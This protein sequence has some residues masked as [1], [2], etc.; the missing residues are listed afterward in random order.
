MVNIDDHKDQNLIELLNKDLGQH[1][2]QIIQQ[3]F[4]Q[5]SW[6]GPIDT[7]INEQLEVSTQVTLKGYLDEAGEIEYIVSTFERALLQ[8]H[9]LQE[10]NLI[11]Q[12]SSVLASLREL[13][14]Y[15]LNMSPVNKQFSS[16]LLLDTTAESML[17][18]ISD[19]AQIENR[20]KE[21]ESRLFR[22]LP[23]KY[24]MAK[25]QLGK[26]IIILPNT[27]ADQAHYFALG[28]LNTLQESGLGDGIC[29]GIASYQEDQSLEQFLSNAEIALKRAKQI[30]EHNICQ[31]FTRQDPLQIPMPKKDP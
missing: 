31:A 17:S 14:N 29:I 15:F 10:G 22:E 7:T 1:W 28:S 21:V 11:P 23:H 25:W 26:L 27:D 5:G 3:I 16:L 30:G 9:Y 13:E 12:R 24:Q 18:H 8:S 19:I 20:Q 6:T 4:V 2:Q